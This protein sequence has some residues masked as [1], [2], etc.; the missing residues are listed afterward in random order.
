MGRGLDHQFYCMSLETLVTFPSL[1][2]RLSLTENI[3]RYL[4]VWTQTLNFM[5]QEDI[6]FVKWRQNPLMKTLCA[7]YIRLV[8]CLPI[9]DSIDVSV[10]RTFLS[11]RLNRNSRSK[12]PGLLSA[13]SIES[14]LF[15][16]PM[17]TISPRLSKPSIKASSVDTIELDRE[18]EVMIWVN[19][20]YLWF[21]SI[22][23]F[24]KKYNSYCILHWTKI[25]K[26]TFR[27]EIL[28][29]RA[30]QYWPC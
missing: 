9:K 14:S 28:R 20:W 30:R 11:G 12:R 17:T 22:W 16:A 23:S 10:E 7:V 6:M 5:L 21:N 1:P 24:S 27:T 2:L 18:K 15:V 8:W 29:A 3:L 13:G 26:Q 19:T 4:M 25:H